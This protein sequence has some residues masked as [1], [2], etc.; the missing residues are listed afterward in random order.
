MW[1]DGVIIIMTSVEPAFC[2]WLYWAGILFFFSAL[3]SEW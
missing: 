2:I 3:G 1:F